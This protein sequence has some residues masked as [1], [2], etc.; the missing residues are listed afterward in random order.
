[1]F[2]FKQ[3]RVALE[4]AHKGWGMSVII[5]VAGAGQEIATR[6]F[7]LVTGRTWKGTNGIV[8]CCPTK[9]VL[10]AVGIVRVAPRVGS[11]WVRMRRNE[12]TTH[13]RDPRAR[14]HASN[15]VATRPITRDT[16]APRSRQ[17]WSPAQSR[18]KPNPRLRMRS[19]SARLTTDATDG[20]RVRRG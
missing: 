3:V 13:S 17:N 19:D 16:P 1:M 8:N 11:R 20:A 10:N 15:S 4:A 7:Q 14:F 6:P 12:V 18:G 2:S 9:S 5:G